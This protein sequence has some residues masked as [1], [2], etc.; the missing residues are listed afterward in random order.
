MKNN[1]MNE[2]MERVS[3]HLNIKMRDAFSLALLWEMS[4]S[5][6]EEMLFEGW[7]DMSDELWIEINDIISFK[8]ELI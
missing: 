5:D 4:I 1:E 2:M 7:N 6:L 3:I 8:K